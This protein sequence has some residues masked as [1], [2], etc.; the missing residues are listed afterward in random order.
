MTDKTPI[1]TKKAGTSL[2]HFFLVAPGGPSISIE[3][4]KRHLVAETAIILL[5][6][7]QGFLYT[8]CMAMS[9]EKLQL[10]HTAYSNVE[11]SQSPDVTL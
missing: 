11:R 5:Q 3:L 9:R 6:N 1:A 7:G 2:D 8:S 10:M 4:Q